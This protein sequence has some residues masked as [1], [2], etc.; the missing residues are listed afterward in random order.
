MQKSSNAP[1]ILS[2]S[3]NLM[4]ICF[5]VLTSLKALKMTGQ[6][7]MDECA[8]VAVCLFMLSCLLS[9]MAMRSTSLRASRYETFADYIFMA[10]LVD[11]C[12]TTLFIAF[13]FME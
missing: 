13:R 11:L 3:A 5:L 8:S 10:G 12:I 7:L 6:T 4:G 2:T 1:H 9:F